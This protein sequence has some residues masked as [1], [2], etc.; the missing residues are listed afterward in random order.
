MFGV[1][2]TTSPSQEGQT[3][4]RRSGG[5]RVL[6]TGSVL[7]GNPEEVC[8]QLRLYEATGVDQV[9]FGMP[10]DMTTDDAL[11]CIETFGKHVIP[12]YDRDPVHRTDRMRATA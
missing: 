9:T 12:E 6:S 8:E 10:N 5:R 3:T 2:I 11:E 7:C 1:A 4:S